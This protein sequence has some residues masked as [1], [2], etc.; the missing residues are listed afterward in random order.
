MF[1]DPALGVPTTS[2]G[3]WSILPVK[4]GLVEVRVFE[5][6]GSSIPLAKMIEMVEAIQSQP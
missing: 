6:V 4:D 3:I 1:T 5:T 2:G